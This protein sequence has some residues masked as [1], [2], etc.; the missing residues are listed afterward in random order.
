MD[1]QPAPIVFEP[2]PD[3]S[4]LVVRGVVMNQ[5]GPL[6]IIPS[7]QLLQK[8]Q[9]GRGIEHVRPMVGELCGIDLYRAKDL[10]ALPLPSDRNLRLAPNRC[11][12]LIQR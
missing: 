12:S 1:F 9:I 4:V 3:R 7:G 2:T 8:N 6:G 10:D 5:M 11:P